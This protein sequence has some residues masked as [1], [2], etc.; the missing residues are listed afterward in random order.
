[1]QSA[2]GLVSNVGGIDN[3]KKQ[4]EQELEENTGSPSEPNPGE[5]CE[6]LVG[7]LEKTH[8]VFH[9][10]FFCVLTMAKL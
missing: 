6:G 2:Y 5:G 8:G 3:S 1:M 10:V 9:G 4:K 7:L